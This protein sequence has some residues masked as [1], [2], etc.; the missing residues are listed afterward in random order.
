MLDL[1]K[2]KTKSLRASNI[3]L[4]SRDVSVSADDNKIYLRGEDNL[5]PL[6]LEKVIN[7][8]TTARRSSNLMAKFILGKGVSA[9]INEVVNKRG[10]KLNA[11]A[12][13]AAKSIATQYGVFFHVDYSLDLENSIEEYNFK[14]SGV[15]VLD[16]VPMAKGQDDADGFPGKFFFLKIDEKGNA[17]KKSSKDDLWYYPYNSDKKVILA[18]MRNDCKLKK[19]EKPTI[20]QLIQNYR[21]QVYYLN[22][23]PEYQYALPPWDVEYD[24]MDSEYRISRYINTQTRNGWLGKT[25]VLKFADDEEEDERSSGS[26]NE[27]LKENMGAENSADALVID[28]PVNAA[29]DVEKAFKVIQLEAQY[30]DKLFDITVKNL[31]QNIM[32]S[33]NNAPEILVY[34]GTGAL[35]GPNSETYIEAKK[36]YWEQ[37]EWE[38]QDL[39][40]VLTELTGIQ[41]SFLPIVEEET[42]NEQEALRNKSQA[43]LKG[44][45]GGVTSLLEIQKSVSVGTTDINAGVE[46]IKEIFGIEESI[47]RKMLGTPEKTDENAVQ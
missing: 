2:K 9:E 27:T 4:H 12:K 3:E 38:R 28:I 24:N 15:K 1:G 16:Y 34:A 45:V 25:V 7:N 31:R 32:G 40:S 21:G 41:V 44:S 11:I 46:I 6:T 42:Y 19:I 26:F 22:L 23:T 14:K 35:F 47:A 36:F 5:Y 37:C 17:F 8:S 39:E 10:E 30:D 43:E 20:Q 13:K 29:D 18:Q 33:F